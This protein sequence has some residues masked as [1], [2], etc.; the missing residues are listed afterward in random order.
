MVSMKKFGIFLLLLSVIAFIFCGWFAYQSYDKYTNY[1]N[2]DD[3]SWRNK[4]AYVGG[5]AYYYIINGTYFTALAVYAVGC[6]IAGFVLLGFGGYSISFGK[7]LE[8]KETLE[9]VIPVSSIASPHTS[10][11]QENNIIN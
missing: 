9:A 1:Y 4:N 5:D 6:G 10:L 2:S 8:K 7:Y 3:Y 11:E